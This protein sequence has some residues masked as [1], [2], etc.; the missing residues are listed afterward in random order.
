MRPT[1]TGNNNLEII[2]DKDELSRLKT[3]S[4][5]DKLWQRGR[6]LDVPL[7]VKYSP[8]GCD[9]AYCDF[10]LVPLPS[11]DYGRLEANSSLTLRHKEGIVKFKIEEGLAWLGYAAVQ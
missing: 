9:Y 4:I 2:M 7:I 11:C 3:E 6:Q 1:L 10:V 8:Q 5:S